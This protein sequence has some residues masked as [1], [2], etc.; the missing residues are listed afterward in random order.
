MLALVAF[1]LSL[2]SSFGQILK[3]QADREIAMAI[4]PFKE[5]NGKVYSIGEGIYIG[6]GLLDDV[7]GGGWATRPEKNADG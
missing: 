7:S 1:S 2:V 5:Y 3:Q 4:E 6:F